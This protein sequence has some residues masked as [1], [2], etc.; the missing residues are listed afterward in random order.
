MASILLIPEEIDDS[1]MI[2]NPLA[3]MVFLICVPPQ[4]SSEK[5][6][7]SIILTFEPYL[8]SKRAMAPELTASSYEVSVIFTG[9]SS[10]ILSFT[11][12]SISFNSSSLN[13]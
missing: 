7:I 4:S 2:L 9:S 10:P 6:S 3:S 8:P 11:I 13:F 12:A 5:F 1:E